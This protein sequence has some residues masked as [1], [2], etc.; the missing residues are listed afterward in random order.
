[1]SMRTSQLLASS[2]R[3]QLLAGLANRSPASSWRAQLPAECSVNPLALGPN[4]R[5]A[6]YPV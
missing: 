1:M 3:A 2:W 4:D 6:G 5:L